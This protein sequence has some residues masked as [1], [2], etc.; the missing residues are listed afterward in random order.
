MEY[1]TA[2]RIF[3]TLRGNLVP[4][5]RIIQAVLAFL[6]IPAAV[7]LV[8][9]R[10]PSLPRPRERFL[11]AP[12]GW[13]GQWECIL[14]ADEPR[15]P[16]VKPYNADAPAMGGGSYSPPRLS[17]MTYVV[18]RGDTL[19][20]IAERF[21]LE[22]DTVSSLNRPGGRGVHN[23]TVGESVKIPN[24]DGIY[25]P[26]KGNLPLLSE[27]Y[28]LTPEQVLAV[29]SASPEGPAPGAELFFPGA[30]HE[31]YQLSLSLGVAIASPLRGWLSS[32]FGRRADPFTGE[33][34]YH[35]G[36][37]IAAAAGTLVRSAS[38]G[39]VSSVG[40]N[41][42]LGNFVIVKAPLGF[43]YTYGH[44]DVVLVSAGS[45]VAQGTALGR[46]GS[47]GKAT[48]PHLHFS[49]TKDGVLQNPRKYLPGVR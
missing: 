26:V 23:L 2:R 7:L 22:M 48:G 38:D 34:S 5:R 9:D 49:V 32:S 39:S 45:R 8:L 35:T 20:K 40:Y 43:Q 21:G 18:K 4:H 36:I 33:P 31:G 37:D 6:F 17:F 19:E 14:R 1:R 25:I 10:N 16:K 11:Y 46:V 27:K 28:G 12:R 29:N 3:R 24:Q 15:L 42:V 47:T 13:P 44:F 30:K 41:D